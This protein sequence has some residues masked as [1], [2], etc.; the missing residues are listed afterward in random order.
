MRTIVIVSMLLGLIAT[1]HTAWAS[2]GAISQEY[3]G[4]WGAGGCNKAKY[5]MNIEG[6]GMQMFAAD[7]R[8]PLG[9]WDVRNVQSNENSIA[10]ETQE[11]NSKKATHMELTKLPNGQIKLSLKIGGNGGIDELTGC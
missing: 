1:S 9:N 2:Q 3:Q 4:M 10:I 7:K 8:T 6:S 11:T 5:Y